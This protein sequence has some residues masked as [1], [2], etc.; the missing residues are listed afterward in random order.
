MQC[1]VCGWTEFRLVVDKVIFEMNCDEES[2][3]LCTYKL[4]DLPTDG[5]LSECTNCGHQEYIFEPEELGFEVENPDS[6]E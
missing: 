4:Q 1:E 3:I 6:P 5:I 2:D